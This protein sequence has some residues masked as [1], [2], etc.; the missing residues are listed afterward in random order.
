MLC[1]ANDI[2]GISENGINNSHE[3]FNKFDSINVINWCVEPHLKGEVTLVES[4]CHSLGVSKTK[5]PYFEFDKNLLYS[6][7]ISDKPYIIYSLAQKEATNV[8][9]GTCKTFNRQQSNFLISKFT[10]AFP[11]YDFID[12]SLLNTADPFDLYLAVAQARSFISIDTALPHFASNEFYFKK[13]I[14]LWT[15]EDACRRFGYKDQI[16]LVSNFMHPFDD[17]EVIVENLKE[18][19]STTSFALDV[20]I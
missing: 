3:I 14:V 11:D 5:L 15:H 1:Q 10:K 12:L 17:V 13:G 6:R 4:Y 7:S 16:N 9:F 8:S 19:L 2:G 18:V 20:S